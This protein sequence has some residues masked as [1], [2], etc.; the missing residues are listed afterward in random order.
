M[1]LDFYGLNT[2]PF[3]VTPDPDFLYL[4]ACH[5]EALAAL[6]YGV[7]TRKGFIVLLGE[8]GTGKTTIL[9][10]FLSRIDEDNARVYYIFNPDIP[11]THLL[12]AL[13]DREVAKNEVYS[14]HHLIFELQQQLIA[15]YE[16][17]LTII[18]IIDEAQHMSIETLEKLRLLSNLETSKDKLLQIILAGQPELDKKLQA[19]ELRQLQQRIS[20]R[21]VLQPLSAAESLDYINYRLQVA[22]ADTLPEQAP[23]FTRKALNLLV[24]YA[25]GCPR[26]LNILCDNALI[27]GLG[28]YQRPISTKIIKEVVQQHQKKPQLIKSLKNPEN[29]QFFWKTL[30]LITIIVGS[31][32]SYW[33]L[34]KISNI[35]KWTNSQTLESSSSPLLIRSLPDRAI[36]EITNSMPSSAAF[37]LEQGINIFF[38]TAPQARQTK[39]QTPAFQQGQVINKVVQSGDTTSA[40]II[41]VYGS[42][43]QRLLNL[44][45]QYNPHIQPIDAIRPGDRLVFPALNTGQ[46]R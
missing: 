1:Y 37:D 42:Y 24:K 26:S 43:S 19:Y 32:V 20:I 6:L 40:L 11:F 35:T 3:S 13:L 23:I 18:L 38:E 28:Y 45:Q 16:T 10:S 12:L 17:G 44:L 8:V 15:A 7:E 21:A 5:K 27:T 31:A 46:S 34:S 33:F 36:S 14:I 9:R 30:L 39:Q 4:S 2:E 22:S 29:K 41:E 25:V